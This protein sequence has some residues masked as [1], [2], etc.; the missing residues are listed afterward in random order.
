ML[1][2]EIVKASRRVAPENGLEIAAMARIKLTSED[3]EHPIDHVFDGTTGPGASYWQAAEP[4]EQTIVIEFDHPQAIRQLTLEIEETNV[5]RHQQLQLLTSQD[6]GRSY[7]E[8]LRQEFNFSP[9][10]TTFEQEQWA[11][12]R[13]EITH[14]KLW[15]QPDM[16]EKLCSAKLTS[17]VL[18]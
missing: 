15:I 10:G 9:P 8:I 5:S 17:I 12:P 13:E 11:I 6:G 1:R 18:R 4:G 2:K 3:P 7:Q 16:E 14:I